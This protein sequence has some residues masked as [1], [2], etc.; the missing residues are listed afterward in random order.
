MSKNTNFKGELKAKKISIIY[1]HFRPCIIMFSTFSLVYPSFFHIKNVPIATLGH[2]H[3]GSEWMSQ[4]S[5]LQL[6]T[7]DMENTCESAP[8]RS[9]MTDV[10]Q[11]QV[12]G[13]ND[14]THN[15]TYVKL[16]KKCWKIADYFNALY[17]SESLKS[18]N[19][20]F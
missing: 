17:K 20:S 18:T 8:Y 7:Y 6:M 1:L 5:F 15:F 3:C 4:R 10:C 11:K 16:S 9:I 12:T 2:Q 19:S 13:G 14:S